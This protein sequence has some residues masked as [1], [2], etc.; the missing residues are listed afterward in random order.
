MVKISGVIFQLSLGFPRRGTVSAAKYKL[1]TAAEVQVVDWDFGKQR[2]FVK[3]IK[4]KRIFDTYAKRGR[5]GPQ[6]T[7]RIDPQ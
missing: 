5:A 6:L 2:I 4:K 3:G 7:G 1:G